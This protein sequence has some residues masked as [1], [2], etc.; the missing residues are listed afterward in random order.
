MLKKITNGRAALCRAVFLSAVGLLPAVVIT[1]C[2]A[3]NDSSVEQDG[4]TGSIGLAITSPD[5]EVINSVRYTITNAAGVVVKNDVVNVADARSTISLGITLPVATG[6]TIS[7]TADTVQKGRCTGSAKFDVVKGS[8]TRVDLS[9][10]CA[11]GAGNG[12]GDVVVN[13]TLGPACP[14]VAS[15]VAAPLATSV[16]GTIA[17]SGAAT[18]SDGVLKWSASSGTIK[19]PSAADT[20]FTCTEAGTATVTLTVS[21]GESCVDSKS[22]DV[23]CVTTLPKSLVLTDCQATRVCQ[24]E[25]HG[26]DWKAVCNNG[27]TVLTG[28]VQGQT[29]TWTATDGSPCTATLKDGQLS[30]TC[31]PAAGACPVSSKEA[32]PSPTCLT[33][34]SQLLVDGCGSANTLCDVVQNA[35]TWQATCQGGKVFG[36]TSTATRLQ[37]TA[38]DG[39]SCRTATADGTLPAG[40]LSGTCTPPRTN[41]AGVVACNFT[42]QTPQGLPPDPVCQALPSSFVFDGC[43]LDEQY[44]EATGPAICRTVQKGCLWQTNCYDWS[45]S[46]RATD[47][48]YSWTTDDGKKCTGTLVNG[49]LSGSCSSTAGTC[50]FQQRDPLPPPAE[51][52]TIPP[53]ISIDGCQLQGTCTTTQDGCDWQA[54]C[55]NSV[56]YSGIATSTGF[57]LVSHINDAP[58]WCS[59][60]VAGSAISGSCT[61]YPVVDGAAPLCSITGA[62]VN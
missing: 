33:V 8:T 47:S 44:G 14:R 3:G 18:R 7:M 39:S 53:S 9:L 55:N 2:G 10:A 54:V 25:Q 31:Q 45:L 24:L 4:E 41:P 61:P 43:G 48:T 49:K 12:N 59:L 20:T 60:D 35:C 57:A 13:G 40:A 30:G 51:C 38:A 22:I 5:G 26:S 19:V 62:V 27:A 17:L 15:E 37:W 1:G 11:T 28:T 52:Q 46:G 32:I 6:Y 42:T 16:G 23:A 34:P 56:V 36:G 21:R 58:F 29:A 50:Q